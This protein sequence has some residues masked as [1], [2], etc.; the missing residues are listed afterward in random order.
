MLS[1][2]SKSARL[3]SI[4]R[5]CNLKTKAAGSLVVDL[6]SSGFEGVGPIRF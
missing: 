1:V 3:S 6:E 5:R 4:V 2:R